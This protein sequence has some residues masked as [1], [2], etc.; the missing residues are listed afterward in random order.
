MRVT[1][2][3]IPLLVARDDVTARLVKDVAVPFVTKV[4]LGKVRV[5]SDEAA[6]VD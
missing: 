3:G 4:R 1:E 6:D 5:L 2:N